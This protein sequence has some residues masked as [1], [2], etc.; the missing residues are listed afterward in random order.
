ME[1]RVKVLCL[2]EEKGPSLEMVLSDI[3][4]VKVQCS[5]RGDV[6]DRFV[7]KFKVGDWLDFEDFKVVEQNGSCLATTHRYKIVI[8]Y[9][10]KCKENSIVGGEDFYD[11]VDFNL[12]HQEQKKNITFHDHSESD[13]TIFEES[14]DDSDIGD[15]DDDDYIQ[16]ASNEEDDI[17]YDTMDEEEGDTEE[18]IDDE[19]EYQ[20]NDSGNDDHNDDKYVQ[21]LDEEEEDDELQSTDENLKINSRGED[22][23]INHK[24]SFDLRDF[25]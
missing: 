3:K 10:T 1:I 14:E 19:D 17:C 13:C 2:W 16:E 21:D 5:F 8:L 4:G 18:E 7:S 20:S 22:Y 25:R 11:F 9:N 24:I 23:S 6:Y 12:I 15:Q